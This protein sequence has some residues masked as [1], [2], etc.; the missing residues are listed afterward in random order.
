MRRKNNVKLTTGKHIE[1]NFKMQKIN[2]LC[3]L[4][5]PILDS[6]LNLGSRYK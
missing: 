4:E 3:V 1:F 5:A 6:K 2:V